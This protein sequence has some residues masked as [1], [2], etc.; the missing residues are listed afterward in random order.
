MATLKGHSSIIRAIQFSPGGQHLLTG[1]H[2][3]T[4]R[5]WS[6]HTR[7]CLQEVYCGGQVWTVAWRDDA[8]FLAGSSDGTISQ[9]TVGDETKAAVEMKAHQ[10]WVWSI[11]WNP[12]SRLLASGGSDKLVMVW[13]PDS[14]T[15]LARLPG[16]QDMVCEVVWSPGD[17]DVLASW[18]A[19]GEIRLWSLAGRSCLHTL[20]TDKDSLA[21]YTWQTSNITFSPDGLLLASRGREVK[22]WRVATGEVA[23]VCQVEGGRVAWSRE[24]DRLAVVTKEDWKFKNISLFNM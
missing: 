6:P 19:G 2:D 18:D 15:P 5:V 4:C 21:T 24:G 1:S 23:A 7:A 14:Q 20:K 9:W 16:H 11:S 13:A 3:S 8:T 17:Q 12:T 10:V 22:V